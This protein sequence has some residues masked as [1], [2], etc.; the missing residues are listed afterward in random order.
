[1]SQTSVAGFV[2]YNGAT[3][4]LGRH[5]A[6][7][8][9]AAGFDFH[10]I[11]ARLEDEGAL[12]EELHLLKPGGPV[13]LVLM[14][15]K[16]SV[17]ECESNPD[18][19]FTTNV[20]ATVA[21]AGTVLAWAARRKVPARVIYVST[22]HLYGPLPR[23]KLAQ[24]SDPAIPRSVYARTKLAAETE[25]R[26]QS[27]TSSTPLMVARVF[28]LLG[29]EQKPNY[30][31]PSLIR[32]ALNRDLSDIPGLDNVRDY[33]DARDVCQDLAVLASQAW[34]NG[35]D[36]VNVC[37]GH[38]TSIR[39]VLRAVVNELDGA[40]ADRLMREVTALPGRADDVE[41]LVGDPSV[42][43][44]LT[45]RSPKSIE[46]DRTVADAVTFLRERAT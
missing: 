40:S 32:R 19:A 44:D 7:S 34:P 4:G 18:L 15:A 30:V 25:L 33:L 27:A 20:S 10:S 12:E 35:M 31:L 13:T 16:V 45:G 42:F 26:A 21:T 41:W 3:G 43:I 38:P 46:L 39:D 23:G 5:F 24:E 6:S 2:L 36:T 29:P 14:A 28:G 22:G 11:Q 37:S 17:P 1:M 8:L 9:S